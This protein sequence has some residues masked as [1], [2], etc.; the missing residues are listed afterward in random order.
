MTQPFSSLSPLAYLPRYK[1]NLGPVQVVVLAVVGGKCLFLF[2]FVWYFWICWPF[3]LFLCFLEIPVLIS[4]P[5]FVLQHSH[6][7][8]LYCPH[9]NR[10]NWNTKKISK[11]QIITDNADDHIISCLCSELYSLLYWHIYWGH[12]KIIPCC[13]GIFKSRFN[14]EFKEKMNVGK[15]LPDLLV[16]ITKLM[17]IFALNFTFQV[18]M[19]PFSYYN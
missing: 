11:S 10:R 9:M 1:L 4:Q 19:M 18:T 12:Q 13:T 17:F 2:L 7:D 5:E 14:L 15:G 3:W 16:F 8:V 6:H